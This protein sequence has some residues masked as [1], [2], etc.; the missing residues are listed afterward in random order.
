MRQSDRESD[1]KQLLL[2]TEDYYVLNNNEPGLIPCRPSHPDVEVSLYRDGRSNRGRENIVNIKY[3][4]N[5]LKRFK[6]D[7]ISVTKFDHTPR[8]YTQQLIK[9]SGRITLLKVF[10]RIK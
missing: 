5:F 1:S 8:L 10:V 3:I 4:K 9:A 7:L 6:V 2:P